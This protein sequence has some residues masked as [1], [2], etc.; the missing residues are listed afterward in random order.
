VR[1]SLLVSAPFA[2]E[3]EPYRCELEV[4]VVR[5]G[6][7]GG[8]PFAV[9]SDT[10]LYPEGGGQPADHGR[11]GDVEVVDVQK[12]EE[13]I[14]HYLERPTV[15]GP[16]RLTL[17]WGRRYDH[18]Q[19]HTAQHLLSAIAADR[20]GWGTTSFHLGV[21]RSDVE[22]DVATLERADLERLE[23]AIA[24]EV[25]AARPVRARRV[26]A[27]EAA[28]LA[29]RS[30][31]LPAGHRGEVRLVEIEGVDV[32]TCGGTHLASTA[33]IECVKLLGTE[34]MRGGTR[35]HWVAG[36][37]VRA[38]L[39]AAE[40]RGDELRRLLE[41]S[42]AE[43]PDIV[44]LR[45]DQL[46][47]SRARQRELETRLAEATADVL[48]GRETDAVSEHF[49]GLGASFLQQVARRLA[50]HDTIRALLTAEDEGSAFFVVV[51]GAA[52]GASAAELGA[53]VAEILGGRGGGKGATY[54]GRCDSLA[55]R[56]EAARIVA[57]R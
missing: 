13:E 17:G 47:E 46:R 6:D 45:L 3:R 32:T 14:R 33:E 18:M 26:D 22:L 12:R 28:A 37:R 38:R 9:L 7:E 44:R 1:Q 25:R 15:N 34:P 40:E 21:E 8:R 2:Y 27:E 5:T 30:R 16:A 23:E 4:D 55:R 19:Q 31:G 11:L 52:S 41:T 35:L 36:G 50:Q 43:M 56:E 29:E 53:R 42:D 39:A 10:I 57:E 48:A 54:Q 20:F 24:A 49:A 51:A